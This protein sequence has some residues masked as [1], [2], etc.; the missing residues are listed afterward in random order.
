MVTLRVHADAATC[1]GSRG[2][3]VVAAFKE[4]Q[5]DLTATFTCAAEQTKLLPSLESKKAETGDFCK[6]NRA[7]TE[8]VDGASLSLLSAKSG[9]AKSY[10]LTLGSLPEKPRLF[11]FR[12]A[13]PGLASEACDVF[14]YAP[15]SKG[16]KP[17]KRS[18]GQ[19][20]GLAVVTTTPAPNS[21]HGAG[22]LSALLLYIG[23]V[24]VASCLAG[25][26]F[27]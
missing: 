7:L 4:D 15:A 9:G 5:S 26:H 14:V 23:G 2:Q 19:S 17:N 3:Y 8:I 13:K 12:C 25:L 24:F 22:S 11:C 6:Q 16:G 20:G 1:D 18:G 21:A 10:K 27:P